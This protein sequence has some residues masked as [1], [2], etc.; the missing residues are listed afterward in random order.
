MSEILLHDLAAWLA[1]QLNKTLGTDLFY[2]SFGENEP[3]S[4]AGI[5]LIESG[6]PSRVGYSAVD[7]YAVQVLTRGQPNAYDYAAVRAAAESVWKL[8]YPAPDRRGLL[9]VTLSTQ[10][11]ALVIQAVQTPADLG[12]SPE[13]QRRSISFNLLV[14]AV[15]TTAG[16]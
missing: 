4:G 14:K 15:R 7:Q 9:N 2:G 13:T 5:C 1:T 11:R 8:V 16:A 12:V 6:G 3:A 10:W